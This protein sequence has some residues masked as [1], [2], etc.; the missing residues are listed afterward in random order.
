MSFLYL[1]LCF[2]MMILQKTVLTISK[3]E[4]VLELKLCMKYLQLKVVCSPNVLCRDGHLLGNGATTPGQKW[5]KKREVLTSS[6]HRHWQPWIWR[7]HGLSLLF[8]WFPWVAFWSWLVFKRV[9]LFWGGSFD[10][11]SFS[12]Q[13]CHRWGRNRMI[14]HHQIGS[15]VRRWQ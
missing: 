2:M 1:L 13:D 15:G 4:F 11:T 5:L 3:R 12:R 14:C 8:L 6:F 9:H 7:Y 10:R